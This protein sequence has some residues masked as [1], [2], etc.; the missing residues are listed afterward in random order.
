MTDD[1]DLE[2]ERERLLELV[3]SLR[4]TFDGIVDAA[5]DVAT[6][7]E[8]DPEGHTIAFER[9]Q[10]AALLR[11]AESRLEE[12]DLAISR[13]EAGE[14]GT[15]ETCGRSIPA[16]RLDALPATRHCVSCAAP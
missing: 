2:V 15:C 5:A 8:H 11:G 14:Y 4:S 7:D 12:I 6:D 10:T 13:L 3:A 1:S 9:Q 16:E